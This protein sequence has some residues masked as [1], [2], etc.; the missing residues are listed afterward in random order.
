MR[1]FANRPYG[2]CRGGEGECDGLAVQGLPS[3]DLSTKLRM[4]GPAPLDSPRRRE[5]RDEG[6]GEE[7]G[8]GVLAQVAVFFDG[9]GVEV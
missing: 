8:E 5:W 9:V 3:V 1:R 7:L 2:G 4:S 6:S